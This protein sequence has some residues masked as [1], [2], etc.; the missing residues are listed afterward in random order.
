MQINSLKAKTE[1]V[2]IPKATIQRDAVSHLDLRN[3]QLKDYTDKLKDTINETSPYVEV[4]DDYGETTI[5]KKTSL[6]WL[7]Q[8]DC[9]KLSS[10][11]LLRVRQAARKSHSLAYHNPIQKPSKKK[12][13]KRRLLRSHLK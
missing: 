9:P 13:C 4:M 7:L 6:C 2:K 5:V 10:D 11:R 8:N 12:T 1:S 3:I